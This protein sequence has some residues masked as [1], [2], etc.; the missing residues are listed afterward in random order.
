MGALRLFLKMVLLQT[1]NAFQ[2]RSQGQCSE[3]FCAYFDFGGF[4][5]NQLKLI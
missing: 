5:N 2:T 4:W 3:S 1:F